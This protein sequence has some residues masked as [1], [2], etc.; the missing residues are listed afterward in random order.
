MRNLLRKDSSLSRVAILGARG[1]SG[2]ELTRI[3]M[4]HPAMKLEF[5]SASSH[6]ELGSYLKPPPGRSL[7][8]CLENPHFDDIDLVFM[9]TPH[10]VSWSLAS[11][12][13][14]QGVHVIDLSGG[15][16]LKDLPDKSNRDIYRQWYG[17]APDSIELANQSTYGLVPFNEIKSTGLIANP[18]CYATSILMALIPLLREEL[19]QPEQIVI[20][21]KSGTTGAGRKIEESLSFSEVSEECLP[22]KVGTHQHQPEIFQALKSLSGVEVDLTMNTHLLNVRR[23]IIS[24]LYLKPRL[25][26]SD[27]ILCQ[28][29]GEAYAKHFGSYPLVRWGHI[30]SQ[31]HLLRLKTVVGTAFTHIGYEVID[32]KVFLFSLLDNLLKG[33][34]SQAVEN[35][36]FL[37]DLPPDSGLDHLEALT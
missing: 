9:A 14:E 8:P 23:G 17:E 35:F 36:N 28:K 11:S 4:R 1:Y 10:K 19:I 22:Y 13:L 16:R 7:P 21:A 30:K 32:G 34:A 3:C 24:S 29:I 2:L 27:Q 18:G 31:P 6:F 37:Y 12:A 33:A 15:F 20:D 26:L 5:V 25:R